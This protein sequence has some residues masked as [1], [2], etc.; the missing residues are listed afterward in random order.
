[1]ELAKYW[2]IIRA[3]KVMIV[4]LSFSALAT[5]TALTY[6][7]PERYQA[8]SI[9][10]VR[11]HEKLKF[12][13][14]MAGKEILDF[15]VS[16]L[17]PIDAP[18]KTYIEV[19]KSRAVVEK[20]VRTLGLDT[21]K[22]V[23]SD[24]YYRELWYRVKEVLLDYL[25][26]TEHLVK[27]GRMI[28]QDPFTRAVDKATR[29]LSLKA[30]KD[31][32]VFEITFESSDP[33]EA[34]AVATIATQ[35][36]AEY[37][38]E[39]DKKESEGVR[40]FLEGRLRD[41]ERHLA[42]AREALRRFKD[43]HN[44][45]SLTDEY[46]EKLKVAGD[47][48]KDLEKIDSSLAGMVERYTDSHPKVLSLRAEKDQLTRS[49]ARLQ[50]ELERSPDKEQALEEMKLAL[51]MAEDKY[52]L[53][54]KVYEDARIQEARQLSDTR[55]VS[56]AVAPTFPLK[57]IRYYYAGGGFAIALVFGI[58][59]AMFLEMQRARIRS[60]DDAVAALG[61]PILA[62]IPRAKLSHTR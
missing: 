20:I 14:N 40:A 52:S 30:K 4:L 33:D 60:V 54:N 57:P 16:Q 18:S 49:L 44:T 25:E 35:I 1:M 62:T 8:S 36:F 31:T 48:Q 47:I 15:P 29:N 9:V 3:Y 24:N 43:S 34:A 45:F 53:V 2:R 61:L 10:L 37:M 11:P 19:I 21:K 6:V 13:Q 39:A 38:A 42:D 55:I 22:R 41:S 59:L 23:P 26:R 50:K 27:Y 12:A 5:S 51:R 56:S 46:V 32:Y 28:E 17:A 58:G 7:L